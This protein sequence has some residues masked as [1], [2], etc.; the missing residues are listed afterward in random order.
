MDDLNARLSDN[1][2]KASAALFAGDIDGA[3]KHILKAREC[4]LL[5]AKNSVGK[6]REVYLK[7]DAELKS[8]LADINAKKERQAVGVPKNSGSERPQQKDN[9]FKF[10]E[11]FEPCRGN[12]VNNSSGVNSAKSAPT[13][14]ADDLSPVRLDDYIGQ[15]QAVN[16]VRDLISAA[17]LKGSALPHVI[18]YGS[19]GLGKTTFAKI[20]ANEMRVGFTEVNV[21]KITTAE[22]IAVLKK[23]KPRDIL[24]IDEI[25][26]LPLVVAESA[27]YSAM[28]DGRVTY[29]EG[30]GKF[31]RTQ[32]LELPPFTLIGATTEIGKLAKPFIQRAVQVRLIEYTDE[33]IATIIVRSFSRL[34]MKISDDNALYIA[35]RCRNNAR[36]A[37]N[38][39]RR[40]SDK[41]LV[42][43]AAQNNIKES[44]SFDSPAAVK[45]LG[46]EVSRQT[47]DRFFEENEID[48]YGMEKG[49]RE[50]LRIVIERFGGGPVGLDTLASVMNESSNVLSKKYETYLIK[51]GMLK[52]DRD[53]RVAMPLAYTA[54]GLVPPKTDK[55]SAKNDDGEDTAQTVMGGDGG[56]DD[57]RFE[58]EFVSNGAD[59]R[60]PLFDAPSSKYEPRSVIACRARD[61]KKC[62]AIDSLIV[63][64]DGAKAFSEPL[65]ALFPDITKDYDVETKHFC[66]LDIDFGSFTRK[67]YC[68]SFLES[69]FAS[70][71]AAAGYLADMKAQALELEYTSQAQSDR[72]YFPDFFIKDRKGR[73]AV[74]EMKNP[75][76]V[77]YHLNIDKYDALKA[78]CA[79]KGY[80]YAEITKIGNKY[81]SAEM[82]KARPIDRQLENFI[83]DT[84]ETRGAAT[85]DGAF[86][87]RDFDEY[88]AQ[89]DGADIADVYAILFNNRALKNVDRNGT[90]LYIVPADNADA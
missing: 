86:T 9:G 19:H 34:G 47:I 61:E 70:Y 57:T 78:Y 27:L 75:E 85:G 66:T 62:E 77:T 69:R 72:R 22:M 58:A 37:N 25:H 4:A 12:G 82:L 48:E 88:A 23:I 35:K 59:A 5:L 53:G 15:P 46:I 51:R 6:K 42:A 7:R 49:D 18:L 3:E 52:I 90:G 63:F 32:T 54:L 64:P 1:V 84:I 76:T 36:I 83:V 30:K 68:D 65:D 79:Q 29:M 14:R 81:V 24:F 33:V 2:K 89:N 55:T 45:K 67:L 71:M 39:V 40:V 17:R 13:P 74:I 80:G 87:A 8:M 31:A 56:D 21:S 41:A 50:L 16:A 73:I 10:T 44:G 43:Y 20:I 60:D 11:P 26:T 38:T 28:Q